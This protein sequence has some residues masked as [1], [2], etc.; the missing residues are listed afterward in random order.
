MLV[1]QVKMEIK[2]PRSLIV[3]GFLLTLSG[4]VLPLLMM[5]K[6]LES[7]FFL[8]FFAFIAQAVGI[9]LGLIGI[10]W[11]AIDQRSHDPEDK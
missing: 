4:A 9:I 5:I 1:V 6:V 7:T 8:N 2:H 10:A 3:I 11:K